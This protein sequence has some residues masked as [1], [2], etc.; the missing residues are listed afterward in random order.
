MLQA[1]HYC[2]NNRSYKMNRGYLYLCWMKTI[3][4]WGATLRRVCN[5]V[6]VITGYTPRITCEL[7]L[8]ITNA[9]NYWNDNNYI[10]IKCTHD[11]ILSKQTICLKRKCCITCVSNILTMLGYCYLNRGLEKSILHHCCACA[12]VILLYRTIFIWQQQ[13]Q[14]TQ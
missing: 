1:H 8:W 13:Q 11:Y 6:C 10:N 3:V 14:H 5:R 4:K 7:W 9:M 12:N 2:V